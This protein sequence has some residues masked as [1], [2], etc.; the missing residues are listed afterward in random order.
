MKKFRET[1]FM[2]TVL[3]KHS[4]N[5]PSSVLSQKQGRKSRHTVSSRQMFIFIFILYLYSFKT[6]GKTCLLTEVCNKTH[7]SARNG[8]NKTTEYPG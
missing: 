8:C 2:Y 7:F 4:V 1:V 5:Q 6:I 3:Y